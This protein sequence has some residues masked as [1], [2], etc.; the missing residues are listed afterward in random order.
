MIIINKKRIIFIMSSVVFSVI[1]FSLFFNIKSKETV[2]TV[3]L[4]ISNKVVILDAG[5]GTPDE[6]GREF[7]WNNRK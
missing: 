5:H 2:Q 4:P 1:S 3:A 7:K 6:R